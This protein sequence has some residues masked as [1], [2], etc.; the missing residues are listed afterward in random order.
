M[1]Y[2]SI[3]TGTLTFLGL[4]LFS[5]GMIQFTPVAQS[6][7]GEGWVTLLD[8]KHM[9]EWNQ[10]GA[11]NWRL[12]D[13]AV[14][15]DQ[16]TSEGPA[17]LVSRNSYA[18]FQLYVEFWASDDANSGIFMRCFDLEKINDRNCY[19]ANIFDQRKDPSYATGAIV[20]HVEVSPPQKAGGKW[21]TYEITMKGRDMTVVLN[22]TE[23]ARLRNGLFSEGLLALQHDSGVIKFRKV[24]IKPL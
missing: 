8:D 12:E 4:V 22:G 5:F 3:R 11:S 20:R 17:Y 19:E 6:Q 15:A 14:V 16:K 7:S 9:G 21:N 23:T 10:V 1:K 24:A 13:G 18:D 2:A